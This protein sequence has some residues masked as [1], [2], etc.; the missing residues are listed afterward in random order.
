MVKLFSISVSIG[1]FSDDIDEKIKSAAKDRDADLLQDQD[2]EALE[3][4]LSDI[5]GT[6]KEIVIKNIE[7]MVEVINSIEKSSKDYLDKTIKSEMEKLR[8]IQAHS[9][10]L[11]ALLS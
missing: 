2:L 6:N 4:K 8:R 11:D 10:K 5:D 1:F 3:K 7:C 9:D